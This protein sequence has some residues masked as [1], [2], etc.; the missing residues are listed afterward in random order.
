MAENYEIPG[1]TS[2]SVNTPVESASIPEPSR[3]TIMTAAYG[4]P[5]P[6]TL[7]ITFP[8]TGYTWV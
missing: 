2:G 8:L 7:S 5:S 4:T 3:P 6:V 1:L